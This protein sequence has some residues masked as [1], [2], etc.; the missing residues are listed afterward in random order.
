M[1]NPIIEIKKIMN[2]EHE[3]YGR[4]I[5]I[6]EINTEGQNR[7]KK[8]RI[9]CVGAGGLNSSTLLYLAACG[10]G[11]IGVIDS[12]IVEISN[13]QR[14][15]IY[16]H[17]DIDKKKALAVHEILASLNPLT[18]VESYN[19]KLTQENIP[20][21]LSN[22]EIVI[23]GTDNFRARYLISRHCY[24]SHKIHVYGAIEK[25]TGQVSV[26]NHQNSGNYYNLHSKISYR[27][28]RG[29]N[30]IGIIN[31][32]AGTTGLLQAAEAIKI[33]TG[34]GKISVNQLTVFDWLNLSISK[35]QVRHDKLLSR[36]IVS[37]KTASRSKRYISIANL[38]SYSDHAYKLIDIRTIT[39]FTLSNQKDA[40]SIPLVELKKQESIRRIEKIAKTNYI[41]IYCN[42]TTRSHVA[43][44]IL[45]RHSIDH[46]IFDNQKN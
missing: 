9:I 14:Q 36:A 46:Y 42:N 41:V 39:E 35:K 43:S 15:I 1:L 21:I 23:D 24:Q 2:Q 31:T 26:F 29:C 38:K 30:D 12:D 4:Q 34:T 25:F 22:Y 3:R 5:I 16:R 6:E 13:L 19:Q 32:V 37:K 33:T 28:I 27:K 40:I 11:T 10:V 17:K 18:S 8:T 20:E 44:R 45:Q 7:L